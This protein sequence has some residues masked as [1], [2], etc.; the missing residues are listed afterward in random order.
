MIERSLLSA[1][2]K[3]PGRISEVKAMLHHKMFNSSED[4]AIYKTMVDL[5]NRGIKPDIGLLIDG[6]KEE[7][8]PE[9]I[10][11]LS[12]FDSSKS[13]PEN[14]KLYARAVW[15]SNNRGRI[16]S[17]LDRARSEEDLEKVIRDTERLLSNIKTVG[18]DAPKTEHIFD[19]TLLGLDK[20]DSVIRTGFPVYDDFSGGLT[21][22]EISALGGRPGHGKTTF[23][24]NVIN[25]IC[26]DKNLKVLLINREMKNT[27]TMKKLISMNLPIRYSDFRRGD[28]EKYR[29][30][31][32]EN[33]EDIVNK[34]SN[35]VMVEDVR[36]LNDT[37]N[38]L[39]RE[40]PDVWIDDYIQLMKVDKQMDR[41]FQIEEIILEYKWF[42][43]QSNASAIVLSQMNRN[44][45]SRLEFNPS[46]A[47]YSEGATIEH[48]VEAGMFITYPYTIDSSESALEANFIVRKARYGKP[49]TY[50]IGYAPERCMYTTNPADAIEINRNFG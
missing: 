46:L 3:D 27:E 15:E 44:V 35:L 20:R 41:R 26:R 38:L 6:T 1:L 19:S 18:G 32:E 37:M 22:G 50:K 30:L 49:G 48:A 25:G 12:S 10:L 16:I 21:R 14:V 29:K 34:F 39:A 42:A 2:I 23:I 40:K 47:D 33:K 28:A 9:Y 36:T 31:I 17:S 8:E 5:F 13:N 11:H 7:C 43:K 45:E 24:L 4:R